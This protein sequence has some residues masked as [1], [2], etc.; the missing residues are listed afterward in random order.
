MRRGFNYL[1]LQV[2]CKKWINKN[3]NTMM[4]VYQD[5][6]NS[7][8]V[9]QQQQRQLLYS[10]LLGIIMVDITSK[11]DLKRFSVLTARTL[12]FDPCV[13]S[14]AATTLAH[15]TVVGVCCVVSATDG[16]RLCW[17]VFGTFAK[18]STIFWYNTDCS[19]RTICLFTQFCNKK[20]KQNFY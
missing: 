14:F 6:T 10:N 7:L 13:F 17:T 1:E 19:P 8:L 2:S 5:I 11:R 4:V 3:K 12:M 20:K 9:I 16:I 18:C 15:L